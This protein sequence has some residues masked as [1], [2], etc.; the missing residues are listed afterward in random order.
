MKFLPAIIFVFLI[1]STKV[2]GQNSS[3]LTMYD[4]HLQQAHE[5]DNV[6]LFADCVEEL[7]AAIQIS[8]EQGWQEKEILASI[9]LAEIKRKT[10]DF[11][12]SL[13]LLSNLNSSV[14]Y[15]SLHVRKLGRMAAVI[16]QDPNNLT[17]EQQFDT[18]KFYLDSALII[19]TKLNSRHL[20][21]SL[22]NELGYIIG[23]KNSDSC[24][25][26]LSKAAQLFIAG[27]DTQNYVGARTNMLRTYETI[28]DSINTFS[29]LIEL[30]G[31]IEGQKW[32]TA[33]HGLYAI[34]VSHYRKKKNKEQVNY[35][36]LKAKSSEFQNLKDISSTQL[37]SYR[38]LYETKKFQ[39]EVAQKEMLLE[40]GSERRKDFVRYLVILIVIICGIGLLLFRERKLKRAVN[41]ANER[42]HMLLVESNHRI[43]NNLQMII[44]M[45]EFSSKDLKNEDSIAFKKISGKIQ[46]ISALHKHLYLDVHN[47]RVEMDTYFGDIIGLYQEITN[48]PLKIIK[49]LDKVA[50]QSE[51]IVYFGLIFNE[52]L[53]NT[54][55][56][57]S[58]LD[59]TINISVVQLEDRF[60]FVYQDNSLFDLKDFETGTGT[61]LIEQLV[62]R[63]E[64]SNYK[65]EAETG[66]Y[67]FEFYA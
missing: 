24:L 54:I 14:D 27:N 22:Y 36:E 50:I 5:Y 4:V 25:Y 64:G 21:A 60:N 62:R 41:K 8:K 63:I 1:H 48:S 31:L 56:H 13:S 15:P 26:Y 39:E 40:E 53:S 34:M 3:A 65:L 59:R 52:M 57:S 29:T 28:G 32:H 12:E 58:T 35:W 30:L 19:A 51:R 67:Q 38:A 6:S 55:E 61:K 43:K 49:Q 45:L 10:A 42:Y 17:P 66:K 16:N 2:F 44:S 9:F 7:S 47:E 37:D 23:S 33:E 46:T 18:V 20:R 11:T